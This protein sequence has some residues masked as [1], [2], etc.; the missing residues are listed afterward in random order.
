MANLDSMVALVND[1]QSE[2]GHLEV[3]SGQGVEEHLVDEDQDLV[4]I[5]L[6]LPPLST[7][8]IHAVGSA[9]TS[10]FEAGH[11][12][13]HLRLL[14]QQGHVVGQEDDLLLEGHLVTQVF[15]QHDS[16]EGLAAASPEVD[17]DIFLL[18]FL[19]QLILEYSGFL[20]I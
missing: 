2:V 10:S 15:D 12:G 4:L 6:L 20:H 14:L 17:D 5:P 13:D 19:Q 1:Y 8:V 9:V 11:L 7:P 3:T 18:G 16:D